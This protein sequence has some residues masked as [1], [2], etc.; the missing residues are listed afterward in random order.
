MRGLSVEIC[1]H[2]TRQPFSPFKPVHANLLP[3]E[4]VE[5]CRREIR[6]LRAAEIRD[7]GKNRALVAYRITE[8]LRRAS[9]HLIASSNG[10][11]IAIAYRPTLLIDVL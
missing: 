4:P 2:A 6:T 9:F 11:G 5:I 8:R 10:A 7:S 3:P 1:P